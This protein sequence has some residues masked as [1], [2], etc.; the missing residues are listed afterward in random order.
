MPIMFQ[1]ISKSTDNDHH[2]AGLSNG[3]ASLNKPLLRQNRGRKTFKAIG[4]LIIVILIVIWQIIQ[5]KVA[6]ESAIKQIKSIKT[7]DLIN[8]D[9]IPLLP[10]PPEFESFTF[11][12]GL[13]SFKSIGWSGSDEIFP[14]KQSKW[15]GG[16]FQKFNL[17]YNTPFN[18]DDLTMT[19]DECE[20]FFPGLYKDVDR[21][22]Q[23]Y[24]EKEVFDREY[25]DKSCKG[26]DTHARVIIYNNHLYLKS[27]RQSDFTR[28]QAAL[29]LLYFS[30]ITSR[31]KIPNV[32]FCIGMSDWGTKGKFSLDRSTQQEDIWLMPDY[33]FWSWPE[34]VG[35]YND[36]RQKSEKVEL[37]IGWENKINKLIWRGSMKVGTTDRESLLK[38]SKGQSWSD[39]EGVQWGSFNSHSINMEDHCLWKFLAF[40]E[41]NTYS[42]RLRYLQNCRSVIIT[43]EPR[44]IQHWTHLYNPDWNSPD[45]NIVFIPHP[46]KTN[47]SVLV[48]DQRGHKFKDKTWTRLPETM[49]RL[50]TNDTLAKKIANNQWN[51]FRQRYI[52]PASSACYWRKALNGFYKVQNYTVELTGKETSYESF[53]LLGMRGNH[54]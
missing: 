22:V 43:H 38:V 51:F 10:E 11:P 52:T 39:V 32:E 17:Q 50:L 28:S 24:R 7:T 46:T 41:G 9:L 1:V 15:S 49:D 34:H 45:Q 20:T 27:Y 5:N 44:W 3:S 48:H 12:V 4:I 35:S 23:Y 8:F 26:K 30:I 19:Q 18:P 16:R 29:A 13:P 42:G 47:K 2:E 25:L 6:V 54:H 33:G 14:Q 21:S 36:L 31:E 40:P 37:K 53:T